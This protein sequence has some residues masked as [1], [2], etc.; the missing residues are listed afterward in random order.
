MRSLFVPLQLA[1]DARGLELMIDLDPRIDDVRILPF[2]SNTLSSDSDELGILHQIGLPASPVRSVG[3]LA[4]HDQAALGGASRGSRDRRGRRDAP[5]ADHHESREVRRWFLLID[6]R[7]GHYALLSLSLRLT[8]IL[9]FVFCACSNACKFTLSG[10]KLHISTRLVMPHLPSK[11]SKRLDGDDDVDEDDLA[12]P[13]DELGRM[14]LDPDG[15]FAHLL[16]LPVC[17]KIG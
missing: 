7:R 12:S 9:L 15:A 6:Q 5:A 2:Y 10:G 1:T 13:I 14:S 4:A 8:R 3:R 17:L 11:R 16:G